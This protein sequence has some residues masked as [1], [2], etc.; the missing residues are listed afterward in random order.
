M[1]YSNS[2]SSCFKIRYSKI[3]GIN[4]HVHLLMPKSRTRKD[5]KFISK[6]ERENLDR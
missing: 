6:R 4:L 5:D 2:E 1:R 3:L